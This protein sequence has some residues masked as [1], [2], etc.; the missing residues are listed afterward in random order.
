MVGQRVEE[1]EDVLRL[2][3]VEN[4]ALCRGHRATQ[5]GN[6]LDEDVAG[7][8]R[9]ALSVGDLAAPDGVDERLERDALVLEPRQ[10]LEHGDADLLGDVVGEAEPPSR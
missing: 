7:P 9:A 8:V 2:E 4:L 6:G 1:L 5:V 10:R 3:P